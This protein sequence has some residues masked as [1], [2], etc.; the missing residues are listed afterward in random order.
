MKTILSKS[1]LKKFKGGNGN[2]DVY[3]KT[4]KC[5]RGQGTY[6]TCC[7][8]VQDVSGQACCERKHC[9]SSVFLFIVSGDCVDAAVSDFCA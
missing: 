1:E 7:D 9:S 3:H 8:S 6:D 4:V 5:T 2:D